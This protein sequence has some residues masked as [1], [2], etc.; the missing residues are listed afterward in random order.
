MNKNL[1]WKFGIIA[2]VT[3]LSL[4]AMW[5]PQEKIKLGL[6]L[7]GGTSFLLRMDVSKIDPQGRGQALRQA[8]EIL[9]KRLDEFHVAEPV[10]Q[11]VGSDRILV[12]LPGLKEADRE[13][14]RR[15]IEKTA[16]LEF[17]LVHANNDQL[18]AQAVSDPR[19]RPPL[20]YT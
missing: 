17:R 9:R 3:L 20:G 2:A 13:E 8:I 4:W 7:K 16:Y 15:R 14:A 18:E 12:Q 6:D 10:L 5:P 19:F 1:G 11:A